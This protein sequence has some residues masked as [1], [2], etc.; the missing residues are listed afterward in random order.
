MQDHFGWLHVP[1]YRPFVENFVQSCLSI[2]VVGQHKAVYMYAKKDGL[3]L[4]TYI[5][6]KRAMEKVDENK[7]VAYLE[8]SPLG[9]SIKI[10]QD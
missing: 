9:F 1:F 8:G 10:N 7:V 6:T 5:N 4:H 2:H 3:A